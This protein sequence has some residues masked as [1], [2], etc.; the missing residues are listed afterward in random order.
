MNPDE[1]SIAG[2]AWKCSVPDNMNL[3]SSIFMK[4]I[5]SQACRMCILETG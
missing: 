1:W 5:D 2:S 4:K 3:H